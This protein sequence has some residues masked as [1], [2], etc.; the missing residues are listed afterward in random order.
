VDGTPAASP[1]T[2]DEEGFHVVDIISS[3]GQRSVKVAVVDPT[4]V[5]AKVEDIVGEG[6]NNSTAGLANNL[7]RPFLRFANT[8]PASFSPVSQL[9]VST[10]KAVTLTIQGRKPD[11]AFEDKGIVCAEGRGRWLSSNLSLGQGFTRTRLIIQMSPSEVTIEP[12]G[13]NPVVPPV[14]PTTGTLKSLFPDAV[15]SFDDKEFTP[16]AGTVDDS[17]MLVDDVTP[18]D[19]ATHVKMT[20]VQERGSWQVA[21]FTPDPNQIDLLR[22]II[23]LTVRREDLNVDP[24]VVLR[25]YLFHTQRDERKFGSSLAVT[26]DTVYTTSLATFETNPFTGLG[27]ESGDLQNGIIHVGIERVVQTDG[28]ALTAIKMVAEELF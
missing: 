3:T 15:T 23:S 1:V 10:N 19:D 27:W 11:Q 4:T 22:V 14:V 9:S 18:D 24:Q 21:D 5:V 13:V 20:G 16:S 28:L 6:I 25:P 2:F 8:R 17:W 7:P 12:F 26:S